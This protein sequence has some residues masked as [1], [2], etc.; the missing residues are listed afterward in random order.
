MARAAIS[1]G[2][3]EAAREQIER[4]SGA[5][6]RAGDPQ[7]LAEMYME[8]GA[9]LVHASEVPAAIAELE[10][11]I[12][13]CTGGDDVAS[14][15]GPRN[16]W[17][18]FGKLAGLKLRAGDHLGALRASETALRS[19]R[20]V[21]SLVGEARS[22]ELLAEIRDAG[23]STQAAAEHRRAAVDVMRRLGDRRSTAKLLV[24]SAAGSASPQAQ[25]L[26]REAREL[27][28]AIEWDEG[29]RRI[30]PRPPSS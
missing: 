12:S 16:L 28:I 13:L 25:L 29:A 1:R 30:S 18:I 22:L 27:A 20:A 7:L 8:L 23:G 15:H 17:R 14:P 5:A 3:S 19:A 9:L 10:E 6:I 4:A 11:G 21:G 2:D 26:L 24:R